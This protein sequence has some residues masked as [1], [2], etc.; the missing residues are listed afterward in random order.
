MIF[1]TSRGDGDKESEED[2][3]EYENGF[4]FWHSFMTWHLLA[5]A[6][7]SMYFVFSSRS[8]YIIDKLILDNIKN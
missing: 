8:F 4:W 1:P 5:P 2:E 6:T 3:S 7:V